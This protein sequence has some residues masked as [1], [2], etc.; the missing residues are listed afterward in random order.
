MSPSPFPPSSSTL[1]VSPDHHHLK[2]LPTSRKPDLKLDI[3]SYLGGFGLERMSGKGFIEPHRNNLLRRKRRV[4]TA[5]TDGTAIAHSIEKT[6]L[7]TLPTSEA[8]PR[9]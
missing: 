6:F 4:V 5:P 9:S 3:A 7:Q 8:G 1:I 2:G